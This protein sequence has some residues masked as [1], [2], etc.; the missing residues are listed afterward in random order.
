MEVLVPDQIAYD[1]RPVEAVDRTTAARAAAVVRRYSRGPDDE[2]E[3]LAALGLAALVEAD[4]AGVA[5]GYR[6]LARV[7]TSIN[8]G[9]AHG[10]ESGPR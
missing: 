8:E 6:E 10:D 4:A 7:L 3:L 2:R 5:T 9:Q 1:L